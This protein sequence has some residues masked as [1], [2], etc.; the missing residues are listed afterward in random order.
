MDVQGL[1]LT[2]MQKLLSS[3]NASVLERMNV[4]YDSFVRNESSD[5]WDEISEEERA[6]IEEGMAQAE[7]GELL[8]HEQVMA[9][10][11]QWL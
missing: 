8:S 1:K 7:R 10:P 11:K 3:D 6:E 9:N 4:L 2:L 5:W